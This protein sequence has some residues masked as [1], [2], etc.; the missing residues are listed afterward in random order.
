MD[1]LNTE[2]YSL[3]LKF[4]KSVIRVEWKNIKLLID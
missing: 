1:D 4:V 2:E 3:L